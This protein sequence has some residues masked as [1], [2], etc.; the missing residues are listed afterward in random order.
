M[1]TEDI[2]L[3]AI[4]MDGTLLDSQKKMP[5]DFIPWVQ[6]H[7]EIKTVIASGRQ[8][9]TLEHDMFPIKDSL[10]F[11]AENGGLVFEKGKIET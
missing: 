1:T 7:P 3:V 4:D 10:I 5:E 2:K 11:I 8:Y 9:Y 6:S